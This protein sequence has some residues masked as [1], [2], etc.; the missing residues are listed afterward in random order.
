[1]AHIREVARKN[2]RKFEVRWREGGKERQNTFSVKR[3]AERFALMVENTKSSGGTTEPMR[4]RGATVQEIVEAS[5]AASRPK[6]KPSTLAGYEMVYDK[7]VLPAFGKKRIAQ[8]TSLEV[9]RW[10]AAMVTAGKASNTIR[11]RYMALNKVF[12]YA[13]RHRLIA[14]NPCDAVELPRLAHK[15]GF[16]PVFLTALQVEQIGDALEPIEPLG[17]VIR[18]AAYTGLRAAELQG[19]RIRDVNLTA[20]HVE[21]RQTYRPIN[22]VWTFG[23]PKSRRSTRDVPLLNRALIAD[24]RAHLLRHPN[25]G[26][27]DALFW[28]GRADHTGRTDWRKPPN[29]GTVLR[30]YLAPTA[31][32]LGIVEH[33]R[34]HDLRH[35][36]ASLML[37]AGFPVY[38]V[39]RYMGHG[40][41]A[42]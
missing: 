24:L 19:L 6:L 15:E 36:Y 8:V 31:K 12:R 3:D 41:V 26:D 17:T 10:I 11:N 39:S 18:F 14:H 25:S 38:E 37:A 29:C 4:A 13:Q 28:P 40:S 2:G 23:T 30:S 21:V 34:F 35:T 9:E 33:I 20:G 7:F 32:R 5:L 22:G 42:R 1:M 27:P 16:A